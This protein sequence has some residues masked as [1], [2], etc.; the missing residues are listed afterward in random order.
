MKF[1][2]RPTMT[3]LVLLPF[4]AGSGREAAARFYGDRMS[5]DS[6][7]PSEEWF[8]RSMTDPRRIPVSLSA[9]RRAH[10]ILSGSR[11]V[12]VSSKTSGIGAPSEDGVSEEQ[13]G[14]IRSLQAPTPH[15]MEVSTLTEETSVDP[16]HRPQLTYDRRRGREMNESMTETQEEGD[17]FS[18]EELNKGSEF[19]LKG[20]RREGA[21]GDSIER[22][23]TKTQ[24]N[25]RRSE[26][27]GHPQEESRELEDTSRWNIPKEN[28]R[29][30]S[31]ASITHFH[32]PPPITSSIFPSQALPTE[33]TPYDSLSKER[34]K[35]TL[36]IK[37]AESQDSQF[38]EPG[39]DLTSGIINQN[40][41]DNK[42]SDVVE[43]QKSFFGG[44]EAMDTDAEDIKNTI[45]FP[46]EDTELDYE[47]ENDEFLT[48]LIWGSSVKKTAPSMSMR[49]MMNEGLTKS[50]WN[51]FSPYKRLPNTT[52]Y[53][54]PKSDLS[55]NDVNLIINRNSLAKTFKYDKPFS[56]S[57]KQIKRTDT[58]AARDDYNDDAKPPTQSI[59]INISL[60]HYVNGSVFVINNKTR[61]GRS[62][63]RSSAVRLDTEGSV[64]IPCYVVIFLLGMVGNTLVIV[65][66]LQNRKMRTVTNVFLLNLAI[67]D[68]LLGVFCMPFTLV[69]S[70]LRDF[71]FGDVMCRIIPYFQAVS[72]SVSVWTLVAISLERYYAICQPLRSR[73]WQ[74][75][76]HAYKI[77]TL[78]WILSLAIMC[79]TA[80]LS[81]LMPIGNTGRHKCREVW[82][83]L[84]LERL[85]ALFLGVV[86]LLLPLVIM[87]AAYS[88][89]TASLWHVISLTDLN[90]L[91]VVQQSLR[92]SREAAPRRQPSKISIRFRK[93]PATTR[94]STSCQTCDTNHSSSHLLNPSSGSPHRNFKDNKY[95]PD[96]HHHPL[97]RPKCYCQR[98]KWHLA[99]LKEG[100]DD[101][102]VGMGDGGIDEGTIEIRGVELGLTGGSSS[103]GTMVEGDL[104]K[105]QDRDGTST[106]ETCSS[107]SRL[108]YDSPSFGC[109][110]EVSDNNHRVRT[111]CCYKCQNTS[112]RGS[113]MFCNCGSFLGCDSLK[114][115]G[116]CCYGGCRCG[117][118]GCG[119]DDGSGCSGSSRGGKGV[120][121]DGC[122]CGQSESKN[123]KEFG[124]DGRRSPTFKRLRST[125][126]EKSI[127]AK[128]H[129][130]RMLFVVVLLFFVCWTPIFIVNILYLFI[131]EKVYTSL[132]SFGISFLHLLSYFSSCCNPITYCFMNKKFLQGFKFAFGCCAGK[133]ERLCKLNG[134]AASFRSNSQHA[135]RLALE[136][137]KDLREANL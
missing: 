109:P 25:D 62:S 55:G 27:F 18:A 112:C 78:V 49:N 133:K 69:G 63:G 101:L 85:F 60:N 2:F 22:R 79:P 70:L 67:A 75:L 40:I 114:V 83:S 100:H 32:I 118:C 126:L 102:S 122:T 77:I 104:G 110:Y 105:P 136:V 123:K 68:L 24:I 46:V 94:T 23:R 88:S 91:A 125:H 106:R 116:C 51:G 131:P 43:E 64:R 45:E 130:V 52:H 14:L 48:F 47:G 7:S 44:D 99:P 42:F 9:S 132:G 50:R 103:K 12:P 38:Y 98:A 95:H 15:L 56:S 108:P 66:L 128:K 117:G 16:N 17:L 29:W 73:G 59:N 13:T 121:M 137:K 80:A 107:P 65:T 135:Y 36:D 35:T 82:P 10:Q 120:S 37:T 87:V 53:S 39:R 111:S 8:P 54:H 21:K 3:M 28:E 119:S 113:R 81:Q 124:S 58:T 1:A 34:L 115:V 76:S 19:I 90:S 6:Q 4:L 129:V 20:K 41:K 84:T 93:I 89:I 11:K 57:H 96:V 33:R 97:H 30:P 71:I 92:N 26:G 5:R 127:A 31:G 61:S 134:T 72:V 74:T 86:L